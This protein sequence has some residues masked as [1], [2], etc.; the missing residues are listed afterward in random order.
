MSSDVPKGICFQFAESGT[1]RFGA[2]CKYDHVE[3]T[4]VSNT[5]SQASPKGRSTRN[6]R[7]SEPQIQPAPTHLDEFFAKYPTFSYNPSEPVM[8]EFYRMSRFLRWGRDNEEKDN[9]RELL[10]DA[11]SMQFNDIYGTDVNDIDSWRKLCQVLGI[12][13]I[14]GELE[15]C[16]N[17]VLETHVNLVDL[18]DTPRTGEAVVLFD[19]EKALSDYTKNTP[20]KFFPKDSAYAGGLLR[21]LLRRILHP[22][23]DSEGRGGGN[24]Q[25]GR[26]RV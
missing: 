15:A 1:C 17:V 9:A 21:F 20:G 19:S 24:A 25:R 7:K 18:V 23:S 16:R 5:T 2:R 22:P 6:R 26:G 4:N 11:M 10:R 8:L 3:N 12:F 14:P 13:P